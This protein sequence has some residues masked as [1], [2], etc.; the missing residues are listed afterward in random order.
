MKPKSVFL[1]V[2]LLISSFCLSQKE[3][4][5]DYLIAYEFT[6][7]E[8]SVGKTEKVFY[9][10]NS[11]KNN[12]SALIIEI[13]SL[14]YQI[15]FK[16]ENGLAFN[17]NL[18]KAD[19]N[20]SEFI[21]V[22][23]D[24]VRDYHNSFKYLIKDYDFVNLTDTII[25]RTEYS[26]YKLTSIKPKKE[27]RKKLSTEFYIIDKETKFHLPLF[28]IPIAYQE[29]KSKKNVPNG[30]FKERYMIDFYGNLSFKEKLINYTRIDKKVRIETGC[31]NIGE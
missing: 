27:K 29:W 12:Y 14:N 3:Y 19:F 1:I 21:T 23:C 7:Y 26:R 5:F 17:I 20:N 18:L 24:Y 8:D 9:L 28:Y 4:D 11:K 6:T 15:D 30:I 2:F 22:H 10:T 16:D 25:E 31:D 13:D